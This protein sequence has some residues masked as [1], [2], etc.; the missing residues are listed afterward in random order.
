MG[1]QREVPIETAA[2]VTGMVPGYGQYDVTVRVR[3]SEFAFGW[4][5]E[6]DRVTSVR[7]DVEADSV[8]V[9]SVVTADCEL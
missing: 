8:L 1:F 2:T 4:A 9:A 7:V 6:R 5:V 3:D